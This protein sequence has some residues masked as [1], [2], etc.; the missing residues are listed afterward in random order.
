MQMRMN[1]GRLLAIIGAGAGLAY[2][3]HLWRHRNPFEF[4]GAVVLITGGSRGLGLVMARQLADEGARLVLVARDRD[5]L[6]RAAA[7]LRE[8]GADVVVVTA[9]VA[10]KGAAEH[11]IARAVDEFG[12]LDVLINNAG[13]IQAGPFEHMKLE[14][15]EHAMGVHFWGPL[16]TTLAAIPHMR[17]QRGGRIVN[18][19]SIG[20]KIAVPHL[21]PYSASKFALQGLSDGFRAELAK[22]DIVVTTVAPGLMRTGSPVNAL[23]KG[24]HEAEFAWFLH[25]DAT[26]LTSI[27][28]TRAASQIIDACRYGRPELVITPQAQIAVALNALAPAVMA[29]IM[30]AVNTFLLPGPAGPQGDVAKTGWES[31]SEMAPSVLTKLSDKA[32]VENNEM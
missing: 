17:R 14:D 22:D 25:S 6:E 5:E 24:Q 1:D 12:R 16:Y 3:A 21:L 13:I 8:K 9:D 20:G 18:I 10:D 29:T 7:D 31:R 26:P 15:Y 4:K 30:A 2:A 11:A 19:S 32:T 23:F 28:A 27:S